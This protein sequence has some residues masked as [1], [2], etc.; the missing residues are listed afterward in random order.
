MAPEMTI[1]AEAL[2]AGFAEREIAEE[3][4]EAELKGFGARWRPVSWLGTV[5]RPLHTP[6]RSAVGFGWEIAS[7]FH[8]GGSTTVVHHR[9]SFTPRTV[10]RRPKMWVP[11]SCQ[12]DVESLKCGDRTRR[13]A[14]STKPKM[15]KPDDH[16]HAAHTCH[17]SNTDSQTEER[18]SDTKIGV[19]VL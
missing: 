8:A 5:R 1:T 16:T 10:S 17:I 4:D 14:L 13:T 7:G 3:K 18:N 6:A 12:A 9:E 19:A 2:L 11:R 15:T